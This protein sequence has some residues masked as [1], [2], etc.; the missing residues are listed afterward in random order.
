M[1]RQATEESI[2]S[3]FSDETGVDVQ[4]GLSRLSGNAVLYSQLLKLLFEETDVSALSRKVL[5][6]E[7]D[8]ACRDAHALKGAARNLGLITVSKLAGDLEHCLKTG[9]CAQAAAAAA[10]LEQACRTVHAIVL[11]M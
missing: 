10:Q 2:L 11:T 8:E 6:G 7:N 4:E 9:S 5:L 3:A 1:I